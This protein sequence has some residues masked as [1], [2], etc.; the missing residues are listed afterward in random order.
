MHIVSLMAIAA[1]TPA[2]QPP[3]PDAWTRQVTSHDG[4]LRHGSGTPLNATH[5]RFATAHIAGRALAKARFRNCDFHECDLSQAHLYGCQFQECDFRGLRLKWSSVKD[6]TF[7]RCNLEGCHIEDLDSGDLMIV[8]GQLDRFGCRN[9]AGTSDAKL[10]LKSVTAHALSLRD[11][12]LRHLQLVDCHLR[13]ADFDNLRV[14]ERVELHRGTFDLCSFRHAALHAAELQGRQIGTSIERQVLAGCI[15]SHATLIGMQLTHSSV[16]RCRFDR[17]NIDQ[18]KWVDVVLDDA[19]FTRCPSLFGRNR[20]Q[21]NACHGAE[22][23][24]YGARL[25]WSDLRVIRTLP[26]FGV[27]YFAIV[28]VCLYAAAM[29]WWNT[30]MLN[31]RTLVPIPDW[32]NS[33]EPIPTHPVWLWTL[34]SAILIAIGSTIYWLWCPRV[35]QE[36]SEVDWV[37]VLGRELPEYR[38]T[39]SSGLQR[40][41][42]TFYP[43]LSSV[44]RW[45][46]NFLVIGGASIA[47][48]I[49]IWKVANAVVYL[50]PDWW[51]AIW[52]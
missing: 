35:I 15:F 52:T 3:D 7:I 30:Q 51:N 8:S 17:A 5:L 21:F 41:E 34:F 39:A 4:F 33:I 10:V 36:Q 20:A 45:A 22:N 48:A 19:D 24:I 11:C 9:R 2:T 18:S 27:S 26:F 46:S 14:V 44:L 25:T 49:L 31:A 13:N 16:L 6:V 42:V 40:G 12:S 47:I 23:A 50:F 43:K 1:D 32:A 37:V 38:S 28:A 29:R